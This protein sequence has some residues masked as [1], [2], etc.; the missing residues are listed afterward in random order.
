M[1]NEKTK[2]TE[3]QHQAHIVKWLREQKSERNLSFDIGME[4]VWMPP[5]LQAKMKREGR[6]RGVPDIK[7]KLPK[8]VLVH[9]ELKTWSNYNGLSEPQKTEHE[10]LTELGHIVHMVRE[11]TP[12]QALNRI[13]EIIENIK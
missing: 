4:G 5:R 3:S 13:K 8:G 7:I 1:D 2:Y 10:L 12:E 11:K 6:D 9:I